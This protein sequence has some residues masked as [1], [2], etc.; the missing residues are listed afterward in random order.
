VLDDGRHRRLPSTPLGWLALI[1]V[2]TTIAL[3]VVAPALGYSPRLGCATW[4]GRLGDAERAI[5]EA[6]LDDVEV[7]KELFEQRARARAVVERRCPP[8]EDGRGVGR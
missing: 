5:L 8:T 1:V 3:F 7:P 6:Q 2:A 4:A